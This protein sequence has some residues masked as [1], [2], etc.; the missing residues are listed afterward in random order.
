MLLT[1]NKKS[2]HNVPVNAEYYT[3]LTTNKKSSDNEPINDELVY[4]KNGKSNPTY[5]RIKCSFT[6][7]LVKR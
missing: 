7:G 4:K 2:T 5:K 3:L 6:Y 1:T